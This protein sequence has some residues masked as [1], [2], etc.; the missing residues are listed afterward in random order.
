MVLRE[1]LCEVTFTQKIKEIKKASNTDNRW[2]TL[3]PVL[4]LRTQSS[5]AKPSKTFYV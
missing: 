5:D 1:G 4:K 3:K 2:K